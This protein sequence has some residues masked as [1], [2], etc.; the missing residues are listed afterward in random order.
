MASERV[1]LRSRCLVA[2]RRT[3]LLGLL[4][5]P[6]FARIRRRKRPT[7][8][9]GGSR[10]TSEPSHAR[11]LSQSRDPQMSCQQRRE[12]CLQ[13]RESSILVFM[14]TCGICSASVKTRQ[15]LAGHHRFRHE[16]KGYKSNYR[17]RAIDPAEQPVTHQEFDALKKTVDTMLVCVM[18]VASQLKRIESKVTRVEEG[19]AGTPNKL[20]ALLKAQSIDPETLMRLNTIEWTVPW[21]SI[22]PSEP[23]KTPPVVKAPEIADS[24]KAR[25]SRTP[26]LK[27]RKAPGRGA[28]DSGIPGVKRLPTGRHVPRSR[29]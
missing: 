4:H 9:T 23:A 10:L 13:C 22:F 19:Q 11:P 6:A 26:G 21:S 14:Y 29:P 2:G 20:D 3:S 5:R 12:S 18:S 25:P 7:R 24:P 1:G 8:Q 17:P 16:G 28:D 15:G 27:S